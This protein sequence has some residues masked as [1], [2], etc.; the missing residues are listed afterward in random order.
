[1]VGYY[2]FGG[3]SYSS[4]QLTQLNQLSIRMNSI[5]SNS[6]TERATLAARA[7]YNKALSDIGNRARS[8]VSSRSAEVEIDF[9]QKY[10]DILEKNIAK[11]KERLVRKQE[12]INKKLSEVNKL[13]SNDLNVKRQKGLLK[14]ELAEIK[15]EIL[16]KTGVNQTPK[17]RANQLQAIVN[18][19]QSAIGSYTSGSIQEQ[20]PSQSEIPE[21][22][23]LKTTTRIKS[24]DDITF[25]ERAKKL[26][27][28]MRSAIRSE[29]LAY[30][31]LKGVDYT[32][33][34]ISLNKASSEMFKT[35]KMYNDLVTQLNTRQSY[36][37]VQPVDISV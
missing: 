34:F 12:A 35:E 8:E 15:L 1:M 24:L 14:L 20:A 33:S 28:R 17:L 3:S 4:Q 2:Q 6:Y 19:I 36:R 30:A 22:G 25:E 11:D 13:D 5:L 31:G 32:N 29:K 18:N 7:T 9:S 10:K 21:G 37:I 23:S 26:L 27:T 16:Q